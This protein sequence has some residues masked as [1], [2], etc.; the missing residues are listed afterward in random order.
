[1]SSGRR[2]APNWLSGRRAVP[3]A[4]STSST[5]RSGG[6]VS[7]AGFFASGFFAAVCR[8]AG[9]SF[10]PDESAFFVVSGAVFRGPGV[11]VV[12]ASD[13][14]TADP[15]PTFH[16]ERSES[17]MVTEYDAGARGFVVSFPA[18]LLF[19]PSHTA[20]VPTSELRHRTGTGA[21]FQPDR[22]SP[23]IETPL[24]EPVVTSTSSSKPAA[25]R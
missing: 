20:F 5:V 13:N 22:L 1:M 7:A 14:T 10:V 9:L 16:A 18:G 8:A 15:D 23:A 25:D 4:A 21:S 19:Q 17:E 6:V 24:A 3:P 2:T 11:A 12:V